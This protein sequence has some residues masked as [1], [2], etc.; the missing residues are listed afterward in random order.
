MY[1][2][3]SCGLSQEGNHWRARVLP[4]VRLGVHPHRQDDWTPGFPEAAVMHQFTGSWRY[5]IRLK[6]PGVPLATD[7]LRK[8]RSLYR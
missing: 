1:V 8:Q 7:A 2:S 6:I 3:L 4:I 5:N